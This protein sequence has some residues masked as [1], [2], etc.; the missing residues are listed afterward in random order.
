VQIPGNIAIYTNGKA[1][2]LAE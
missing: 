1:N 2:P